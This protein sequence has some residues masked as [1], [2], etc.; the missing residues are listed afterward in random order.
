MVEIHTKIITNTSSHKV[1]KEQDILTVKKLFETC[2][3]QKDKVSDDT[4]LYQGSK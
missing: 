2:F 3:Q 1:A 4:T